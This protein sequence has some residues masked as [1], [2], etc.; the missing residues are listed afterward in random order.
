M[1]PPPTS[2]SALT[3]SLKRRR[4]A[5]GTYLTYLPY[6]YGFSRSPV[7]SL[8]LKSSNT[9]VVHSQGEP[10]PPIAT[11]VSYGLSSFEALLSAL[12]GTLPERSAAVSHLARFRLWAGSLGAHRPSGSR[13]LAYRLRDASTI[14]NHVISLLQDLC[15]SVDEGKL[16]WKSRNFRVN[17]CEQVVANWA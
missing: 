9:M 5:R 8:V 1:A 6:T 13:S 7:V 3:Q 14:K 16:R 10:Q 2:V 11:I 12:D 4:G 17:R 15:E